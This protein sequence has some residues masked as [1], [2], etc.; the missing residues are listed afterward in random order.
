MKLVALLAISALLLLGC[1][2]SR[3][4]AGDFEQVLA[5]SVPQKN[6]PVFL[7]CVTDQFRDRTLGLGVT[8]LHRQQRRSNGY[9][10]ELV[11][12]EIGP[13]LSADIYDDGQVELYETTYF[14]RFRV[15]TEREGFAACLAK[16]QK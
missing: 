14:S 10:V 3:N 12:D 1:A 6:V 11:N 16:F 9:R 5:G 2:K 8:I 7:D 4:V 15:K 13:M